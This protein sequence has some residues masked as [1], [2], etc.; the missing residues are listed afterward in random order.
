MTL[1]IYADE[2]GDLGW[3]FD[4]SYG[5]GGSSRYLTIFAV[6][7]PLGLEHHLERVMKH[8]YKSSGWSDHKKEKKWTDT[9][10]KA[11]TTFAT[12][13]AK[14]A[15][16]HPEIRYHAIT[17]YKQNVQPHIRSDENKLYNYMIKLLLVQHMAEHDHVTFCPDPRS[18]KVESGNSLHDYLQTELW[19]S[20]GV[21]TQLETVRQYSHNCKCLQFADM[22]AGVVQSRFEQDRSDWWDIVQAHISFKTLYFPH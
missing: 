13:A 16:K 3:S 4:R 15:E 19:F 22:M 21:A 20:E 9:P 12:E 10:L 6:S 7:V 5:H 17:V 8:L 14:L 11:R 1:L 2:S 18:I